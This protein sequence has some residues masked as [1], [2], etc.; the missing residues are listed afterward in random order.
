MPTLNHAAFIDRLKG[1]SIDLIEL[2]GAY[3][4]LSVR[5]IAGNGV[6]EGTTQNLEKL[7]EAIDNYDHDGNVNTI[8]DP[9]ALSIAEWL[10]AKSGS[11]AVTDGSTVGGTTVNWQKLAELGDKCIT[12]NC[13]AHRTA[14]DN[15]GVGLYYGDHS[16]FHQDILRGDHAALQTQI[17]AMSAGD[18]RMVS[19]DPGFVTLENRSGQAARLQESSCIGWVMQNVKGAYEGAGVEERF[20]EINRRVKQADLRG[21]VLCEEL[22]KDGWK[23]VFY[24]PRTAED[25]SES[26]EREKLGALN[27]AK[28]GARI[29][30]SPV[31]GSNGVRCDAVI[32]GYRGIT[33]DSHTEA[34]LEKLENVPFFVGVANGGIHTFVGHQGK[35]CD[36]H[37]TAQPDDKN[38]MMEN[39]V[40]QWKWDTGLYMVPPGY[41]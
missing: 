5:G 10:F 20:V 31:P 27:M 18:W 29:W 12:E 8:S 39:P 19:V 21:T 23:A 40:R 7:W 13:R 2:H 33:P 9:P 38:A 3:P 28:A 14:I 36:F 6:I 11:Q 1:K 37:W 24:S 4:D 30:K 22:Q 41:W 16:P 17:D 25:L 34:L 35:V 26:G 32:S 15:T